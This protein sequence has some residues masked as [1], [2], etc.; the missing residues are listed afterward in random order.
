LFARLGQKYARSE[1]TP[2]ASIPPQIRDN[3]SNLRYQ[4]HYKLFSDEGATILLGN[5]AAG[6][7]VG[8]PYEGWEAFRPRVEEFLAV[9]KES[10]FVR[11]VE[12]LSI[13]FVNVLEAPENKQL[14]LLSFAV[15]LGGIKAPEFGLRF[16][17]EINDE[18]FIR[19]IEIATN[20]TVQ[21]P[22]GQKKTG[23]L[24]SL[25]CIRLLRGED[26]WPTT[27][28]GLEELHVELKQ[29]FFGLITQTTLATLQP[30]Y[31]NT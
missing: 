7:S 20:A 1:A 31:A 23:L 4:P 5:R 13:K 29:L 26:F 12:R 21:L 6:V 19:I 24:L 18:R 25:D 16:R 10:G 15:E 3:D 14:E 9:V 2:I 22:S 30:S 17:T 11:T 8:P 27:R 28:H